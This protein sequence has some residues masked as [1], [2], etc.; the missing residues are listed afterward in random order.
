M[1][2]SPFVNVIFIIQLVSL[3]FFRSHCAEIVCVCA[4]VI[5]IVVVWVLL[6]TGVNH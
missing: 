6:I 2:F 4:A 3:T 1:L 5:V